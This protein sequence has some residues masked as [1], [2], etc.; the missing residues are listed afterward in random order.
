SMALRVDGVG[1]RP[2]PDVDRHRERSP[3]VRSQEER[4]RLAVEKTVPHDVSRVI[5]GDGSGEHPAAPAWYEAMRSVMAPASQTNAR[6]PAHLATWPTVLTA[7]AWLETSPGSVPRSC[8]S[9]LAQRTARESAPSV[10]P[11]HP[12]MLP[13]P[14]MPRA[15]LDVWPGR[16]PRS[17]RVPACQVNARRSNGGDSGPAA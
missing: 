14:L 11:D 3:G 16:V 1:P 13:A 15:W 10:V 6:L 12:T 2:R 9:P 4:A 8:G 5:D 17:C 7:R